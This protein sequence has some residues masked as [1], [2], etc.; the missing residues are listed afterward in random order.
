[1][2]CIKTALHTGMHMCS[3]GSLIHLS[4]YGIIPPIKRG[5]AYSLHVCK[6][7]SQGWKPCLPTLHLVWLVYRAAGAGKKRQGKH[8]QM[9]WTEKHRSRISRLQTSHF[10]SSPSFTNPRLQQSP[11]PR[12]TV[13]VSQDSSY[14]SFLRLPSPLHCCCPAS[15]ELFIT[16]T[17]HDHI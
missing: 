2:E 9:P 6:W 3:Q 15:Q 12:W 11:P 10:P 1:M 5:K 16:S 17:Y 14:L 13:C 8:Q 4:G 7:Q